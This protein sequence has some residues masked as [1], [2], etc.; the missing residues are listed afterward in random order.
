MF[1]RNLEGSIDSRERRLRVI[2]YKGDNRVETIREQPGDKGYAIGFEGRLAYINDQLPR[3]EEVKQALRSEVRMYP[4]IAVR[5]LV[6]N[7]LIHQDFSVTV[8]ARWWRFS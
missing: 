4:E 6:A 5:E 7:A 1:A 2:I 8:L 3:N